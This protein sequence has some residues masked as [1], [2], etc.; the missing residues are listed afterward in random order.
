[1]FN[2]SFSRKF[3]AHVFE[4]RKSDDIIHVRKWLEEEKTIFQAKS[5]LWLGWVKP[6][7]MDGTGRY[8]R[9][10]SAWRKGTMEDE[11]DESIWYGKESEKE[12]NFCAE[13]GA[14]KTIAVACSRKQH[15][16]FVVC[17]VENDYSSN[18]INK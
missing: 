13:S 4:P 6:R 14:N 7:Q 12:D 1:M 2:F 9:F 18:F 5:K 17:E 15:E 10:R 11:M 3:E 16:A 8:P